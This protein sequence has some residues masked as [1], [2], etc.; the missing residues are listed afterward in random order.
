MNVLELYSLTSGQKIK[1]I[2]I[3]EKFYPLNI[4][5]YILFQPFSKPSKC[6][7]LWHD[8]LD[9]LQP[10]LKKSGY[11]LV[12]IGLPAE[13]PLPDCIDLHGK[14]TINQCAYLCS[15]AELIL[16]TDS[17]SSHLAGHYNKNLVV[18]ISNNYSECVRPYFGDKN[19]QIVLEPDRTK[20]KPLFNY[21]EGPNKQINEIRP[22][23]IAYS[24]CHL[25]GLNFDY[26]YETIF[27]GE[28]Y[29]NKILEATLHGVTNISN[30]GTDQMVIRCDYEFNEA[31]L[32]QQM[33]H[34][35]VTLVTDKPINLE[36]LKAYKQRIKQIFYIIA[37]NNDPKFAMAVTRLGIPL[38]MFS[39]LSEE[40]L[41]PYKLDYLDISPI[42][43]K[44]VKT[45]DQIKEISDVPVDQLYY[46][47]SKHILSS[48]KI[49]PSKAAYLTN[50]P[51]DTI[52]QI[53][54]I[55]D[56]EEFFKESEYF[57]LLKKKAALTN[58]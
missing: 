25:L 23:T 51:N 41:N 4:E 53:S 26:P 36:I 34:C 14:T 32:Q 45:K 8:V 27:V 43:H 52:N 24:V 20:R 48:G 18:L 35:P 3:L 40:K 22:E 21:D 17:F 29:K 33:Q 5:K 28:S 55:I 39:F 56:N 6:Y 57:T 42:F 10:I 47:S 50:L 19:K 38:H 30:L 1:N 58:P 7:D 37:E 13:P 12:Q 2:N 46:K 15:K 44:A 16:T 31:I 11:S 9:I 54:P 49:Y